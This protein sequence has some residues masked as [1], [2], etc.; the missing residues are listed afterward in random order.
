MRIALI[1]NKEAPYTTGIYIE[2]IL[3]DSSIRFE[4]FWT[5]QA[6]LIKPEFDLYLRIDHGDYK[7]DIPECLHPCV[8]WAIDTH[9][10]KPY[11]KIELQA[12]HYDFV[13]CAQKQGAQRLRGKGINAFWLPL[14]C[15]PEM[16]RKCDIEKEFAIGFVGTEGRKSLRKVFMQKLGQKYPRSFIGR[17]D[18]TEMSR[19]YSAS[20]IGFNYSINND[21]NMRMFEIM[22]C[23]TMLL[24]NYIRKNGLEELFEQGK[25]LVIYKTGRQLLQ[26]AEYYLHHPREREE[27]ARAGYE[28]VRTQHRY[29]DRVNR[30]FEQ[31]RAAEPVKF[32]GLKL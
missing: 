1:F 21:I 32:R 28:L 24:T 6:H 23:G 27:I 11:K 16:H 30:M 14:G 25:H 17:A 13:F 9:L 31:L 20:R 29:L 19:I 8:F 5:S 18:Y 10:R 22:S 7:Y 2:R 4:H 12:R 3:K 15:A 26:L